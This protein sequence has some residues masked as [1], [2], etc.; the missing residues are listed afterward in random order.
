MSTSSSSKDSKVNE[1]DEIKELRYD[2]NASNATGET[3]SLQSTVGTQSIEVK[4]SSDNDKGVGGKRGRRAGKTPT[5]QTA[6]RNEAYTEKETGKVPAALKKVLDQAR[7]GFCDNPMSWNSEGAR[8]VEVEGRKL[9]KDE[10]DGQYLYESPGASAKGKMVGVLCSTCARQADDPRYRKPDG[11]SA[12]D[13]RHVI[14]V[15]K[16]GEVV[17]MPLR[18]LA[19]LGA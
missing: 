6:S 5:G 7:C 18:E 17:N 9:P 11:T 8:V 15:R 10:V 1:K 16:N 14:V 4:E 2:P 19:S 3:P 13:V 12:I